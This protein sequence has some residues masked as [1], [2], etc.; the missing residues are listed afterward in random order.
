MWYVR[1]STT[2]RKRLAMLEVNLIGGHALVHVSSKTE[3]DLALAP[4]ARSKIDE[5]KRLGLGTRMI[6]D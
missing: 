3:L 5:K 6:R 4:G 2:E 1:C